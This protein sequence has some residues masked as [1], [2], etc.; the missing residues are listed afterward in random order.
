[1]SKTKKKMHI[2]IPKRTTLKARLKCSDDDFVDFIRVLVDPD[3]NNRPTATEALNH[4]FM[5]KKFSD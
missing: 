3:Q 5:L 1:M 2:L 4:P